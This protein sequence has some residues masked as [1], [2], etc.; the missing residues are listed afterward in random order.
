MNEKKA[1]PPVCKHCGKQESEHIERID[2]RIYCGLDKNNRNTFEAVSEPSS[3]HTQNLLNVCYAL[4]NSFNGTSN[5]EPSSL[6]MKLVDAVEPFD[7]YDGVSASGGD[8]E[9][10]LFAYGDSTTFKT[11]E[12]SEPSVEI[13]DEVIPSSQLHSKKTVDP[14]TGTIEE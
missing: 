3:D 13:S 10:T 5:A 12:A 14:V 2:L 8:K 1:A 7:N 4:I 6:Y 11:A 9:P